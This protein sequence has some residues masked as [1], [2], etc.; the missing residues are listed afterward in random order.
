MAFFP[1]AVYSYFTSDGEDFIMGND[2]ASSNVNPAPEVVDVPI[3]GSEHDHLA[4]N[5]PDV[6]TVSVL[7]RAQAHK[8][9]RGFI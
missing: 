1:V 3:S 8:Q 5:H 4:Q 9:A 6:F 2:I 7:T